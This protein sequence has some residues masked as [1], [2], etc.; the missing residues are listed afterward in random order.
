VT[1]KRNVRGHVFRTFN[2][3]ATK[4]CPS[5]NVTAVALDFHIVPKTCRQS[6]EKYRLP[7]ERG[8]IAH[9]REAIEKKPP[10]FSKQKESVSIQN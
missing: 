5:Q 10:E 8:A 7:S 3:K 4:D 6:P 2:G 1:R 9:S